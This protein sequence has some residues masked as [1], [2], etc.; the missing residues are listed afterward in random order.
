[1]DAI[2]PGYFH[3]HR[4]ALQ[5]DVAAFQALLEDRGPAL[6][7]HL[8]ALDFS[9]DRLVEKWFLSIFTASAI[10]LPTVRLLYEN[11]SIA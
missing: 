9:V 4:P 8:R 10:P 2:L 6:F 1:M 7:S 11:S 5:V 3:G